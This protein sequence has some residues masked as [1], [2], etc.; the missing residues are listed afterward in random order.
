MLIIEGSGNKIMIDNYKVIDNS[1]NNCDTIILKGDDTYADI[2]NA[3]FVDQS[4][5]S[6]GTYKYNI[7]HYS[8]KAEV[9]DSSQIYNK[10]N[11]R[12]MYIS[13]VHDYYLKEIAQGNTK[14]A[15]YIGELIKVGIGIEPDCKLAEHYFLI[16]SR[17][18]LP[19]A[20]CALGELYEKGCNNI[21]QDID[22]AIK[23]YKKASKLGNSYATER[24][25]VL[26]NI[27]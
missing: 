25:E 5:N 19:D 14:A 3:Y 18:G 6:S 13:E 9:Y 21:N 24:L 16:A 11:G 7:S 26:L 10:V 1:I 22:E 2:L 12:W 8:E 4:E 15:F 23:W 27:R 17:N 20:M